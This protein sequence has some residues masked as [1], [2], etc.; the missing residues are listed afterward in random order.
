MGVAA[1][2]SAKVAIEAKGAPH[3]GAGGPAIPCPAFHYQHT[4]LSMDPG[5]SVSWSPKG[6]AGHPW[7]CSDPNEMM[8]LAS[9]HLALAGGSLPVLE[10]LGSWG[11]WTWP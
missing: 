7:G 1:E 3:N 9:L 11:L 8:V 10:A 4:V 6:T 5:I 2:W